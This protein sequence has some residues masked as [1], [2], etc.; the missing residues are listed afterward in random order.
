MKCKTIIIAML[1]AIGSLSSQAADTDSLGSVVHR[2]EVEGVVGNILHTNQFLRGSNSEARTMNRSNTV[3]LKY[4]F[5]PPPRSPQALTYKGAYQGVGVALHDFNPQLGRPV[6][7]FLFQGATIA[8]LAKRLDLN[9][10]WNLGLT[11]GWNPY[12]A[13]SNPDNRVVGSHVTAYLNASFYLKYTLTRQ[14]D[15]NAGVSFS[16]FSNGNTALPNAGLNTLGAKVSLAYFIDRNEEQPQPEPPVFNPARRWHTDLVLYGAWKCKGITS[17]D[18]NAFAIPGKFLVVGLNV[19]PMRQ[20][21]PWLRLGPSL[22]VIYDHSA[23]IM[24]NERVMNYSYWAGTD[25]DI[26]QPSWYRQLAVGLSAH[27]EFT[28]PWFSINLGVGHHLVNA[29]DDFRGFYE[30]LALKIAV[31]RRLFVHIGYSLYDYR[32]PNNLMLGLGYQF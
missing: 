3:A 6:S 5:L 22:D 20:F 14:L 8:N 28:M 4:A 17:D 10:E 9:Y 21:N 19:S 2:V 13:V 31:T 12:D 1:L 7:A 18:G 27:A 32:Y 29:K 30:T 25:D 15:L 24:L 11:M 26:R 16:H 23:N